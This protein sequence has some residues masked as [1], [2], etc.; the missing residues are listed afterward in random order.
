MRQNE[1]RLRRY[2]EAAG[3]WRA[4]WP[5]IEQAIATL[6]LMRAHAHRRRTRRRPAP[7]PTGGASVIGEI[8]D[9]FLS[10]EDLD[11]RNLSEQELFAWWDLW[12]RQAQAGNEVD[13]EAY[14]HGVFM[15]LGEDEPSADAVAS[16]G[17]RSFRLRG[18]GFMSL[19]LVSRTGLRLSRPIR[20]LALAAG[21]GRSGEPQPS[22]GR[23]RRAGSTSSRVRVSRA[24]T[25]GPWPATAPLGRAQWHVDAAA[26]LLSATAT[27]ATTGSAST[28]SW[29]TPCF[30]SSGASFRS[31]AGRATTAACYIRNAADVSVWHQAQAGD[32]KGGFLFGNTLVGGQPQRV[33]L[34]KDVPSP[35]SS[36]PASGT[37]T[38]SRPAGRASRSGSMAP[39]RAS[40][41]TSR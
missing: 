13:R 17:C 9:E 35:A 5:D 2:L 23:A 22:R 1:E 37:R 15:L 18:V 30:T 25:R 24:W 31:R 27:G 7:V 41:R 8:R 26:K 10:E 38:S 29:A 21:A 32:A 3:P 11:L 40:S 14:S 19:L 4:A 39:S 33:N 6:P 28:A 16:K 20:G 34:S 12:L 36:P